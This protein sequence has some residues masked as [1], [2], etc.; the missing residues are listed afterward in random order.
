MYMCEIDFNDSHVTFIVYLFFFFVFVADAA[1][2]V[3]V[4]TTKT[5]SPIH[6]YYIDE[7]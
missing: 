4:L 7:Q 2:F 6:L 1:S 3:L 5:N